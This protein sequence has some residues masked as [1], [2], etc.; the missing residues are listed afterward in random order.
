[1]CILSRSQHAARYGD[2]RVMSRLI[3]WAL[4]QCTLEARQRRSQYGRIP[5]GSSAVKLK[6][7]FVR[8]GLHLLALGRTGE[9]SHRVPMSCVAH[10]SWC[11]WWANAAMMS[12]CSAAPT[13]PPC[14]AT[15]PEGS[16]LESV[17]RTEQQR[18]R[19]TE[20]PAGSRDGTVC[21]RCMLSSQPPGSPGSNTR[22][23][24]AHRIRPCIH[25]LTVLDG[26]I[27]T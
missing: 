6:A 12:L 17:S 2:F 20:P 18:R 26:H 5:P 19:G 1:V 8:H 7:K 14:K 11:W 3:A 15:Q 27:A 10:R 16:R 4:Q 25:H 22:L 24:W 9:P 13:G 21:P 23:P